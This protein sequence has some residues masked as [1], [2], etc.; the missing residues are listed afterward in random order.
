MGPAIRPCPPLP[1][2]AYTESDSKVGK[3]QGGALFLGQAKPAPK[4]LN[5]NKLS[6]AGGSQKQWLPT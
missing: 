6:D 3:C 2:C 5:L 1:P 4:Q